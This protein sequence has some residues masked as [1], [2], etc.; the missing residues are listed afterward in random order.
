MG[1][2]SRE[3][4]LVRIRPR[5]SLIRTGAATFALVLVPVTLAFAL[6]VRNG[7]GPA[8][9]AAVDAALVAIGIA[10][11]ARQL[12]VHVEATATTL[13]GNGIFSRMVEVPRERIAGVHRV[14]LVRAGRDPAPQ[15]L[16][17]DHQGVTVFRLREYFWERDDLDRLTEAIEPERCPTVVRLEAAELDDRFPGARYWFEHSAIMTAAVVALAAVTVLGL[18]LFLLIEH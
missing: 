14:T 12:T 7:H 13:R 3:Q 15:T 4:A 18:V 2:V 16:F 11:L 8:L 10:V 5:R 1:S 17:V 6:G 9:A